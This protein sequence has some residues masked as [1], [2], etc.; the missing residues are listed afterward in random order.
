VV[1]R[2]KRLNATASVS[3]NLSLIMFVVIPI[4]ASMT[5][6]GA[7]EYDIELQRTAREKAIRKHRYKRTK[8]V[9]P[10]KYLWN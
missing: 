4:F 10:D 2:L 9:Q 3:E 6:V 7:A 5:G 1:K 8:P